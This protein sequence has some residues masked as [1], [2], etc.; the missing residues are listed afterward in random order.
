MT[1]KISTPTRHRVMRSPVRA[2][3]S[4]SACLWRVTGRRTLLRRNSP[5]DQ[6]ADDEQRDSKNLPMSQSLCRIN[7]VQCQKGKLR[8]KSH[9]GEESVDADFHQCRVQDERD[10]RAENFRARRRQIAGAKPA[11]TNAP[12][13]NPMI[14]EA[15]I[16]SFALVEC[17]IGIRFLER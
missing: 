1:E 2:L 6:R 5:Y 13:N 8:V 7:R 3:W 14:A 12:S 16:F 4:H 17:G 11:R 9:R 10:L 15:S